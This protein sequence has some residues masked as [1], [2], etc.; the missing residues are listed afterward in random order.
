MKKIIIKYILLSFS[1]ISNIITVNKNNGDPFDYINSDII[2]ITNIVDFTQK[3]NQENIIVVVISYLNNNYGDIESDFYFMAIQ[4]TNLKNQFAINKNIQFY[5]THMCK[6]I[7][8]TLLEP[9]A[10]AMQIYFE[11]KKINSINGKKSKTILFAAII[12]A[13]KNNIYK[14]HI[15]SDIYYIEENNNDLLQ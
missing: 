10:P 15:E 8:D 13:L 2:K 3:I 7:S 12:D 11:G 5:R 1:L 6:G 4:Y 9:S 14:N